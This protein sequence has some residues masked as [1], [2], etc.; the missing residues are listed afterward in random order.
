LLVLAYTLLGRLAA[1]D[2]LLLPAMMDIL[3][4][5]II[6]LSVQ[7]AINMQFI[8]LTLPTIQLALL[9]LIYKLILVLSVQQLILNGSH[10]QAILLLSLAFQDFI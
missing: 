8:V 10:V 2:Q 6:V 9:D 5:E 4:M 1:V 7:S 3:L